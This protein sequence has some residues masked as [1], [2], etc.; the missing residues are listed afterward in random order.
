MSGL[1]EKL[2]ARPLVK[3][4]GLTRPEDARRCGELGVHLA[5]FIFHPQSP[6]RL[7][8]AR[9]AALETGAALRVGVFG[10]DLSP[11]GIR[12]IMAR[13]RLDLA[14]LH[15]DQDEDF[16]RR[17]GPERI[18]RV[19]WPQ[20]FQAPEPLAAELNRFR[21]LARLFLLDAGQMGG[22][23]GRPLDL[24]LLQT[25]T[26]PGP[27]LLAGGLDAARLAEIK[28]RPALANLSGFDLNSGL[29][30]APGRKD[31]GRLQSAWEAA[32]GREARPE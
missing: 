8:P 24:G 16:C 26:V 9:A 14:Q 22:G 23:H 32:T 29:E 25:I 6:R 10:P 5:G 3:V 27:W 7:S 1:A 2:A 21:G 30:S 19:F 28:T 15:A 12:E 13:A 4:C 11:E 31:P 17:L 20:R 18:I